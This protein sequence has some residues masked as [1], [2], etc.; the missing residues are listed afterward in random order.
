MNHS[1]EQLR[2]MIDTI[3]ALAWTCLPD[4]TAEFINRR[5]LDYTGRSSQDSLGWGWKES[6]HPDELARLVNVWLR[7][8]DAGMPSEV[9]DL[10]PTS[11]DTPGLRWC[12][13]SDHGQH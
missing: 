9:F 8:F 12:K 3:P 13:T 11:I 5:W 1:E 4:G 6:V 2:V 7:P 10:K